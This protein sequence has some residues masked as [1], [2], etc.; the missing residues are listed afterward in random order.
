MWWE[1]LRDLRNTEP[2]FWKPFLRS[3]S[4]TVCWFPSVVQVVNSTYV[5]VQ[6]LV[7]TA[8]FPEVVLPPFD[9]LESIIRHAQ[10]LAAARL[11]VLSAAQVRIRRA[12]KN[13]KSRLGFA[14]GAVHVSPAVRTRACV[15]N[16]LVSS[17]PRSQ[18]RWPST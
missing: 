10:L 1:R 8:E 2:T 5:P 14:S 15:C 6:Q 11:A 18:W 7:P 13:Y 16:A 12:F 3:T 4:F 17:L 9:A